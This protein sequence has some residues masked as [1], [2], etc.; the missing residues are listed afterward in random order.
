VRPGSAL[1]GRKEFIERS[2]VCSAR[3]VDAVLPADQVAP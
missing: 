1:S 2:M 3:Q